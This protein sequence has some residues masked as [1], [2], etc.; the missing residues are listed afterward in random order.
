MNIAQR[1]LVLM[2]S[3]FSYFSGLLHISTYFID[4]H[5][6]VARQLAKT[7]KNRFTVQCFEIKT[8]KYCHYFKELWHPSN[9]YRILAELESRYKRSSVKKNCYDVFSLFDGHCTFSA[10]SIHR[11]RPGR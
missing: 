4:K 8:R 11:S 10:V 1:V 2:F 3:L 5:N 9:P 7:W 6:R